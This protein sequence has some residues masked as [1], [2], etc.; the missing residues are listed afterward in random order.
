MSQNKVEAILSAKDDGLTSALT[1]IASTLESLNKTVKQIG[2]IMIEAK[3]KA[4]PTI[5]KVESEADKLGDSDAKIDIEAKDKASGTVKSVKATVDSTTKSPAQVTLDAKD[6]AT[7]TVKQVEAS[8]N[9]VAKKTPK[10]VIEAQDKAQKTIDT[11]YAE[12]KK[13]SKEQ[14]DVQISAKDKATSKIKQ[15]VSSIKQVASNTANVVINAKDKASSLIDGAKQKIKSLTSTRAEPIIDAKD[16]PFNQKVQS[17]KD[18]LSALSN[19]TGMI[20]FGFLQQAGQKAFSALTGSIDGAISRYDTLTQFPKVMQ[21]MG[22]SSQQAQANI[23]KLSD[24]IDG[25]PTTLDGIVANAKNLTLTLG[26]LDKG[27]DTAIAFNNAMLA[28]GAST[29][30]ADRALTQYTQMLA[31]GKVDMQSW[32]S[33]QTAGK[34]ALTE[35]A[36]KLGIASGSTQELYEKLQKGTIS[37]DQFNDALIETA[38]SGSELAKTA[39]MSIEGIGTSLKNLANSGKKGLANLFSTIDQGLASSGT[40]IAGMIDNLK[41]T[42]N[43]FFKGMNTVATKVIGTLTEVGNVNFSVLNGSMETIKKT[44]GSVFDSFVNGGALEK[45]T[46]QFSDLATIAS[47]C[48]SKVIGAFDGVDFSFL[49]GVLQGVTAKFKATLTIVGKLFDK[50][51]ETG[52]LEKVTTAF[53]KI[54]EAV[55]R[56]FESMANSGALDKLL[57]AFV[58]LVDFAADAATK[59]S[60]FIGKMDSSILGNVVTGIVGATSAVKLFGGSFGGLGGLAAKG[61]SLVK[62]ALSKVLPNP[63]KKLPDDASSAGNTAFGSVSKFAKSVGSVLIDLGNGIGNA[64]KGIGKGLE[65]A[66][67]GIGKGLKTAFEGI[68]KAIESVEVGFG[69]M[70]QSIMVASAAANPVSLLAFGA[71]VLMV[72]AA[73]ALVATQAEGIATILQALGETIATVVV[74]LAEAIATV[75]VGISEGIATIITALTPLAEI[76]GNVFV[77]C[78]SIVSNAIVQIVQAIAPFMPQIDSMVQ[79]VSQAVVAICDSFNNLVA[80]VNPALENLRNIIE[81]VFTGVSDTLESFGNLISDVF[82]GVSETLTAFGDMVNNILSGVSGVIDSIGNAALNAGKG[83]DLLAQGVERITNLN[84]FDMGASLA[85]VATGITGISIAAAG[86]GGA[87]NQLNALV[88]SLSA[89]AGPAMS[90]SVALISL[91]ASASVLGSQLSSLGS[92]SSSAFS[93]MG[94]GAQ[95]G[96]SLVKTALNQMVQAMTQA[97]ARAKTAGTQIGT[98]LSNGV[99]TGMSKLPSI[100]SSALSSMFAILSSAQ[101]R[102]YSCGA[103]IGQGLANG[104]NASVGAV[105]AAAA[106]LAAAADEAIR[107][108]ARINSPSKVTTQD[109]RYLGMGIVK[110]LDAMR[111]KVANAMNRLWGYTRLAN[112]PMAFSFNGGLLSESGDYDYGINVKVDIPFYVNG[113]EFAK[114][115]ND[116]YEEVNEQKSKFQRKMKGER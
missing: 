101:A 8:V 62:G 15:V 10:V 29:E 36:K 65:S 44:I 51:K 112:N 95:Q 111:S 11:V 37:I 88:A 57:D 68:G 83:F 24:G 32:T 50:M 38:G 108:K 53:G 22:Y 96:A 49:D 100:A 18:K 26:N 14:A 116:D 33:M 40:S 39:R 93:Q 56:V 35:V 6:N 20:T 82:N 115:T 7:S 31:N 28:S 34:Y 12:I 75:A 91:G 23:N 71:A 103:Y 73:I 16:G 3:D 41:G 2:Q 99:R 92:T 4:T 21:Q 17:V 54:G 109:G 64:A 72:G 105:Q 77:Q 55:D 30:D 63:F 98:G 61:M 66:F 58:Q 5:K 80:Q 45:I 43:G 107:A 60:D 94:T 81:T 102:A 97:V 87:A 76:V 113:R 114:A 104:L 78:V 9:N 47:Q 70:A 52:T 89:V 19:A 79:S 27:T 85:A 84:L 1:K 74:G 110:G 46:L 13:L 90:A 86:L 59:I 48:A 42:I 106:R 67:N 25:L 69:K